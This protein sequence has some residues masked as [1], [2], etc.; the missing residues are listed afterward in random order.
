[1]DKQV[2]SRFEEIAH[3]STWGDDQPNVVRAE[4]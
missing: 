4:S 1:M 3:Q 2:Q